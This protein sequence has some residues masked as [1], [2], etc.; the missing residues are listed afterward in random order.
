ME[1]QPLEEPLIHISMNVQCLLFSVCMLEHPRRVARAAQR[2]TT[3][4]QQSIS[5]L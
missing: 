5:A 3:N 2:L 1:R 4:Y